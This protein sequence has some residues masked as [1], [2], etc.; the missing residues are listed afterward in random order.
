MER[1]IPFEPWQIRQLKR[2][3]SAEPD[4][5]ESFLN[6]L[7][8]AKPGLFQE[9]SVRAVQDGYLS[10]EK[11]AET[12]GISDQEVRDLVESQSKPQVSHDDDI[13]H[14][15]TKHH[16]ARL[17]DSQ[18]AVWEVIREYRRLGSA[19]ALLASFPGVSQ[20][21]LAAAFRYAQAHPE[22]ITEQIS[23][24]EEFLAARRSRFPYAVK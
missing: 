17:A 7:W 13:T 9:L 24:Y 15:T 19:E 22:E 1:W 8:S 14:D 16:I 6:S 21:Q 11:C 18:V 2:V 3:A 23:S 4:R 20:H 5:I 10:V 12:L